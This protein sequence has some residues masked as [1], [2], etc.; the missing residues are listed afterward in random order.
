M[1]VTRTVRTQ[2][3]SFKMGGDE[4]QKEF[5]GATRDMV[6]RSAGLLELAGATN[7]NIVEKD[8]KYKME[9]EIFFKYAKAEN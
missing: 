8:I 3:V 5:P 2:I 4:M 7:I 9:D 1:A 6:E